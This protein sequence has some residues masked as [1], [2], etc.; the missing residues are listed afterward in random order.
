M[1]CLK[2]GTDS[3]G[4]IRF[5]ALEVHTLHIRDFDGE[6]IIQ[7]L[8][9]FREY[10]ICTACASEE[11]QA[12]FLPAKRIVMMCLPFVLLTVGGAVLSLLLT[13]GGFMPAVR[14]LGPVAFVV[15]MIGTAGK[16][17]EILG[18]RET[19]SKMNRDD[20]VRYCAWQ[21]VLKNAP[22]KYNDNDI[23]Y[24]PVSKDT[25][26]MTPSELADKYGLLPPISSKAHELMHNGGTKDE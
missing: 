4:A 21:I 3:P 7:A 18:E 16:A 14:A 9:D 13:F 22:K 6:R 1:P 12:V 24:I 8:G 23:T 10:E 17:R 25:L 26:R 15:G 2:C 5:R 20:A 11:V 19:V